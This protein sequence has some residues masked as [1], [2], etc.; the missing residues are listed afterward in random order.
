MKILQIGTGKVLW[1]GAN[2]TRVKL[3]VG[4][5]RSDGYQF[6]LYK[7]ADGVFVKAGCRWFTPKEAVKHWK[8]TRKGTRLGAESLALVAGLIALA[9]IAKWKV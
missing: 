5:Y 3:I 2:L 1:E 7:T 4:G 8:T 9:K 6:L